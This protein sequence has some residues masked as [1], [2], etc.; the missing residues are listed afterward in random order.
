MEKLYYKKFNRHLK[1]VPLVIDDESKTIVEKTPIRFRNG[2]FKSQMD[3]VKDKIM[4]AI[5]SKLSE[6]Q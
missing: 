1:F 3:E 5:G 4:V 6:E 2:D